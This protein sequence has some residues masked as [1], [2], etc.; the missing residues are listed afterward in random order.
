MRSV[1]Q[2]G[3]LL[4]EQLDLLRH[5]LAALWPE[6]S[7]MPR[8][9][10]VDDDSV[11]AL[12]PIS[13]LTPHLSSG[14][15]DTSDQ[16][17]NDTRTSPRNINNFNSLSHEPPSATVLDVVVGTSDAPQ[18]SL[19]PPTIS[20]PPLDSGDLSLHRLEPS[21]HR[22][23]TS[24]PFIRPPSLLHLLPTHRR[25]FPSLPLLVLLPPG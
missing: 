10:A 12:D 14:E 13:L 1:L 17:S 19:S 5:I 20:S 18:A 15:D 21:T 6:E 4:S 2:C 25:P 7:T 24:L 23:F 22:F 3:R 11:V 16:S 9:A 8:N